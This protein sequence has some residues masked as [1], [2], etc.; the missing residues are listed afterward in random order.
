MAFCG[1]KKCCGKPNKKI[2]LSITFV[3][4][5]QKIWVQWEATHHSLWIFV[6][7]KEEVSNHLVEFLGQLLMVGDATPGGSCECTHF[8]SQKLLL[9]TLPL[10]SR[11][12]RVTEENALFH[13]WGPVPGY[14]EWQHQAVWVQRKS[15]YV[16]AGERAWWGRPREGGKRGWKFL[17]FFTAI[18]AITNDCLP[19]GSK[20]FK[21]LIAKC[22]RL[23]I[24][25]QKM[26]NKG[27]LKNCNVFVGDDLTII[28]LKIV[29]WFN[30]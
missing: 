17:V 12:C 22:V 26:R 8:L 27:N 30:E 4:K 28:C 10:C 3:N 29:G 7:R 13:D 6:G 24:K 16:C 23:H 21:A 1:E 2:Q 25:D 15:L 19:S 9:K 11:C 14:R 5:N 20:R 18:D